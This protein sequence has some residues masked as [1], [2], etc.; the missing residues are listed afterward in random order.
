MQAVSYYFQHYV[1]LLFRYYVIPILRYFPLPVGLPSLT[2]R[3]RGWVCR[4]E[5][6][7][8]C[9]QQPARRVDVLPARG[10]YGAANSAV[11]KVIAESSHAHRVGLVETCLIGQG[12]PTYE[13][14][15]TLEATEQANELAG[16][17]VAVIFSAEDNI[18]K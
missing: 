10:T 14:H 18:L 5:G 1:I 3:G 2:G 4:G 13:V 15:A 11:S 6:L 7:L 12:M 17:A 16:I 8:L 9:I